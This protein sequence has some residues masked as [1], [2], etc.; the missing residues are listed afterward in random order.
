L[1]AIHHPQTDEQ[2]ERTIQTVKQ[3][4]QAYVSKTGSDW[5]EW[6]PLVEFWGNSARSETIEKS[7]F[8][9]TQERNPRNPVDGNW[10]VD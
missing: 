6:I 7:P 10:K 5:L 9:I 2:S 8:Q 3:I 1:G 4:L